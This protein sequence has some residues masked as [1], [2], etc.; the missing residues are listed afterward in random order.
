VILDFAQVPTKMMPAMFTCGRTA[1]WCAHI[2]EQ[3][4]LGKLVRPSAIYVGPAPR[5]PE[6]VE[7]WNE[8]AHAAV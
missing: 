6:A 7:G 1:G 8:V 3:K 5:S 4:Q 2:L